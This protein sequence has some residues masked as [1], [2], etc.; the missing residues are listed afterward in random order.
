MKER[1]DTGC[2]R[3]QVNQ[4]LKKKNWKKMISK[5]NQPEEEIEKNK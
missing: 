5:Y 1:Q 3:P 4:G 2:E